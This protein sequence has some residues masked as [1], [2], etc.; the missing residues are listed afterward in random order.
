MKDKLGDIGFREGRVIET[1][2]VTGGR[3]EPNIAPIGVWREDG[4]Y[5]SK[6]HKESD[7]YQNLLD[8]DV[9]TANIV[10]VEQIVRGLV[11]SLPVED[12]VVEGADAVMRLEVVEFVDRDVWCLTRYSVDEVD[13]YD[14][15]AR[16]LCRAELSLLESAIHASR[17][18]LE[19]SHSE[20]IEH[21]RE[22]VRKTGD[23]FE[24]E[25]FMELVDCLRRGDL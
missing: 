9:C 11:G 24:K 13:V 8:L 6:I 25:L 2:L 21:Y 5:W 12:G 7:T 20:F 17:V 19:R 1:L 18:D 14:R 10:G 16:G 3:R 4:S 15:C 22:I 23:S